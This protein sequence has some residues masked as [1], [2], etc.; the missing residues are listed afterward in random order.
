MWLGMSGVLLELVAMIHLAVELLYEESW[1][2][3]WGRWY[4][5]L[6]IDELCYG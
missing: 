4:Q 6:A 1:L 3:L 5:D 2:D